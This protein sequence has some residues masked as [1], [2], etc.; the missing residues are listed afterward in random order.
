MAPANKIDGCSKSRS[1]RIRIW[2]IED[3]SGSF[4]AFD[5]Y[6]LAVSALYPTAPPSRRQLHRFNNEPLNCIWGGRS[7]SPKTGR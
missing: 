7:N 6:T 3:P 4:G 5:F 2:G 1:L